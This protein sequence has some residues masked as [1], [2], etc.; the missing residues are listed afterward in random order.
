MGKLIGVIATF[1]VALAA[2]TGVGFAVT[3]AGSQDKEVNLDNPDA[4]NGMNSG[5]GIVNYGSTP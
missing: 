4:P 3:S 1:V 2:A 5:S